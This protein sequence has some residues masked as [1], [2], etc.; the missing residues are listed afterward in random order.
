MP[1]IKLSSELKKAISL[2]P[3][4]EKDKMLYR[5]IAKEPDLVNKLIFQLLESGDSIEDRRDEIKELINEHLTRYKSHF[6]T[7]GYLQMNLRSLSGEINRHLKTTK[8]KY[9]EVA[10]NLFMLNKVMELYN[11]EVM[12]F[13]SQKSR[14]FNE[15]IVKRTLKIYALLSKLHED[16]VADFKTD[17]QQLGEKIGENDNMMRVAIQNMLDVNWLLKG[18]LPDY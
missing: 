6:Y 10:L 4:Q 2:M 7:P 12:R 13:D 1:R 8:D 18:I 11:E 3:S 5:L 15:Y 16:Y 17:L 9:G 14:T